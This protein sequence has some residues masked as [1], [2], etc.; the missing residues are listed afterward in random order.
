MLA[1]QKYDHSLLE[2][3]ATQGKTITDED[4]AGG[5]RGVSPQV[6]LVLGILLALSLLTNFALIISLMSD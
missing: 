2:D 4:E 3:L 6:P 1:R 5:R